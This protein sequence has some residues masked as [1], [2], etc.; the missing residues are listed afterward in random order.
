V[1]V[2]VLL[3]WSICLKQINDDDDDD[4]DSDNDGDDLDFIMNPKESA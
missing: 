1:C 2:Y 4:D 3:Y